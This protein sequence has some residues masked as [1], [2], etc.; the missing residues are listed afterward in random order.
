M[1]ANQ[2]STFWD[3]IKSW[4]ADCGRKH[5][6][7]PLIVEAPPDL[8]TRVLRITK[9]DGRCDVHLHQA[10]EKEKARYAALSHC[11]GESQPLTTTKGTLVE[12]TKGIA[13]ADLPKIFKD[14][15]QA[16]NALDIEYLWIDSLCIIQ[17]DEEDWRKE[18]ANMKNIFGFSHVT[19]AAADH[20]ARTKGFSVFER[21]EEIAHSKCMAGVVADQEASPMFTR[22]WIFQERLL[23]SR[24]LYLFHEEVVFECSNQIQCQCSGVRN[25]TPTV[26]DPYE[27]WGVVRDKAPAY[28]ELKYRF[29]EAN[30]EKFGKRLR[31]LGSGNVN[32]ER[33][34]WPILSTEENIRM[35]QMWEEMVALYTKRAITKSSDR[36]PAL[37]GIAGAFGST[38]AHGIYH[39]GLWETWL[40][41]Q[42]LWFVKPSIHDCWIPEPLDPEETPLAPSWSWAKM[43]G[44][45]LYGSKVLDGIILAKCIQSEIDYLT[46]DRFGAVKSDILTLQGLVVAANLRSSELDVSFSYAEQFRRQNYQLVKKGETETAIVLPDYLLQRN[47]EPGGEFVCMAVR[48]RQYETSSIDGLVL[49][50]IPGEELYRRIGILSAPDRWFTGS[51]RKCVRVR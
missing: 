44:A 49:Q 24:I 15:V 21:D 40:M 12:H 47:V 48:R 1:D 31:L 19:L 29:T 9:H 16:T 27:N 36:L 17:D 46:E 50:K 32:S 7:C 26:T 39:S 13:W 18:S 5:R 6:L 43:K 3:Q 38:G 10:V 30:V 8:P 51:Q 41:R 42:M 4:I 37:S 33:D 45:F 14:A 2:S 25:I 11:W 34:L 35:L 22:A 20:D 23:A 28:S